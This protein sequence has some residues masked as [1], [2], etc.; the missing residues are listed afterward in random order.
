MRSRLHSDDSGSTGHEKATPVSL[1]LGSDRSALIVTVLFVFSLLSVPKF[2]LPG[3]IAFGT[4]PLFLMF[5]TRLDVNIIVKRLLQIS[6]F[7]LFMAAGNLVLDRNPVMTISGITLS[8]GMISGTVIVAK[9]IISVAG[10]LTVT[11]CIPFYRICC[12]LESLHVPDLLITQLILLER[13]SSVL[14]K[15]AQAMQKARDIRSFGRRG[16]GLFRTA[17]LLGSLLL[18]TTDRAERLYRSMSARGF[19]GRLASRSPANMSPQ[20]WKTVGL[21]TLFFLALRLIF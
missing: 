7:V 6:P 10:L 8:G 16:K 12:A 14:H 4:F 9:T 5:A 15:E 3:V 19:N 2:N 18:R 11:L 1:F 20:E 21:W 17:P 13:Y